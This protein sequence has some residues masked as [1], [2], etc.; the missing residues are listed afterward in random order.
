MPL[1]QVRDCPED[2]YK[3]IALVAK[4]ENRSIAQQTVV[5]LERSLGQEI[6]NK[7]RRKTILQKIEARNISADIQRIDQVELIRE[8]RDR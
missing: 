5:L 8:D 4:K 6:S 1:L 2:V 7:E 3:K